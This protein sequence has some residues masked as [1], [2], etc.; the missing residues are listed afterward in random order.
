MYCTVEGTE[1][2]GYKM[3]EASAKLILQKKLLAGE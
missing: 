3:N 2:V 1:K